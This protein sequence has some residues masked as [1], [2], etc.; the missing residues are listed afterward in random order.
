MNVWAIVILPGGRTKI[1]QR[2]IA[3]AASNQPPMAVRPF[4]LYSLKTISND[5]GLKMSRAV[6]ATEKKGSA[7]ERMVALSAGRDVTIVPAADALLIPHDLWTNRAHSIMLSE[8]GVFSK[9]DLKAL[10]SALDNI[11]RRFERGEWELDPALEDVH[12]CVE[13]EVARIAGEPISGRMHTG[14]S[15]NDQSAT[16]VRLYL[17][18]ALLAFMSEWQILLR[19]VRTHAE[20]HYETVM[21]GFT[22]HRP[23]TITTWAHWCASYVAGLAR[24]IGRLRDLYPRLNR[25]P[26]GGAASYGTT[27]NIRCDRTADLLGFASPEANCL[28]GVESRGEMGA[29]LAVACAQFLRHAARISQDLILF[30]MPAFSF[31]SLPKAWTTGSSIM[32]QKR[33]P[34]LLEVI[35]GRATVV[36]GHAQSLLSA[37][38]G[39]L[40]GYN[41]DTQWT[42]FVEM[43]A[44]REVSGVADGLAGLFEGLEIRTEAMKKATQQGF[45]EAVDL[46]DLLARDRGLTFRAAY[47][48]VSDTVAACEDQGRLILDRVNQVLEQAGQK[49]MSE[50]EFATIADPMANLRRREQP[51]GPHPDHVRNALRLLGEEAA[52]HQTWCEN[53]LKRLAQ[54]RKNVREYQPQ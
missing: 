8:I 51:F 52:E 9:D 10:L 15:R 25:S 14:R 48:I 46:A 5:E 2:F 32:P 23:A 33:N 18:D 1:A 28:D 13:S 4:L 35:K 41:R 49:P 26:L 44:I 16:D 37:N 11:E 50:S 27:W 45:I 7:E 38:L 54:I 20:N 34:D 6:W 39:N 31:V 17:R 43:D 12:M 42:K 47:R 29:D 30:S 36:M 53:E 40:S 24:D 3:G 22:H 19:A 21:P